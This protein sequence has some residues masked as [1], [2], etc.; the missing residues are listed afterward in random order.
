MRLGHARAHTDP[1]LT[2]DER[3]RADQRAKRERELSA[4]RVRPEDYID[5]VRHNINSLYDDGPSNT[6]RGQALLDW[7]REN[8]QTMILDEEGARWQAWRGDQRDYRDPD[9]A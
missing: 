7:Y 9:Q 3:T 1:S 5:H 8:D 2:P 6:L 4:V